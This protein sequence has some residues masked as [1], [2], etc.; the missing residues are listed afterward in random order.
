M[1][2]NGRMLAESVEF[3]NNF[4][5]HGA[6]GAGQSV[7]SCRTFLGRLVENFL[8]DMDKVSA[9]LKKDGTSSE[10][11]APLQFSGIFLRSQSEVFLPPPPSQSPSTPPLNRPVDS[12]QEDDLTQEF[13]MW[14]F[15]RILVLLGHE[16]C[17]A[18][19]ERTIDTIHEMLQAV[20]SRDA[21]LYGRFLKELVLCITDL[22]RIS[23]DMF[24]G[25]IDS[26]KL[27][28]F[29]VNISKVLQSLQEPVKREGSCEVTLSVADFAVVDIYCCESLQL[30]I[31]KILNKI[32][33]DL[34]KFCLESQVNALWA[35][36]CY[37]V[38]EGDLTLKTESL[39]LLGELINYTKVPLEVEEYFIGCLTAM[40]ELLSTG[41]PLVEDATAEEIQ[42]LER[43]AA[44]VFV[45]LVTRG[46]LNILSSYQGTLHT[47]LCKMAAIF[48]SNGLSHLQTGELKRA[49]SSLLCEIQDQLSAQ[50]LLSLVCK[51]QRNQL[52]AAFI[53]EIGFLNDLQYMVGPLVK[54]V[55]C[56]L[57]VK[58]PDNLGN[59]RSL[60]TDDQTPN[61]GGKLSRKRKLDEGPRSAVRIEG[62]SITYKVLKSK[63]NKFLEEDIQEDV[64]KKM[65]GVQIILEIV[66]TCIQMYSENTEAVKQRQ[67]DFTKLTSWLSLESCNEICGLLFRVLQYLTVV[68]KPSAEINSCFI[69]IVKCIG[70]LLIVQEHVEYDPDMYQTL[71]W[72]VSLPWLL[73]DPSWIDLKPTNSRDI[74]KIAGMLV[75]KLGCISNCECLNV[76]AL[77]PKEVAPKWRVHVFRQA[78]CDTVVDVKQTAINVFPIVLF[79]LG[80]NANHLVYDI[81]HPCVEDKSENIHR[82]LAAVCGPLACVVSRKAVINKS[83][84]ISMVDPMYK[85]VAVGCLSCDCSTMIDTAGSS[86]ER[87]RLVDANM[88]LPFLHLVNSDKS[89]IKSALVRSM[90]RMFGHIGVR[91]NNAATISVLNTALNLI[92][93]TDY[94]V[95]TAFSKVIQYLLGDSTVEG[96]EGTNELVLSK[97]R[98]AFSRAQKDSNVRLQETVLLTIAQLGRVSEGEMLMVV[99][100][101]LL[102]S[103]LSITPLVAAVAHEE[104][105]DIADHK[106][107][108]TQ[109]L[110]MRCRHDVCKFLVEAMHNAQIGKLSKSA[111]DI[112]IEVSQ[113]LGFPDVKT[114]LSGT[115]KYIVPYLVSKGTTAASNLIKLIATKLSVVSRSKL[116]INNTKYVFSYLVRFKQKEADLQAAIQYLQKETK[117]ELADLLRIDFQR[118]HNELLLHLGT[119]YSQVFH[120][121]KILSSYDIQYKDGPITTSE[122]MAN[123]LQ[124]RLLGV[125]A[126]FDS[127]LLQSS[128]PME[129]KRPALDSLIS[130][131]RLM[132]SKN[133]SSIRHKVMNTLRI[134]LQFTDKEFTEISCKGWNCFVRSLELPFLGQMLPQI[135]ATLLPLLK[136]LPKQVAEIFNY[137]IVENRNALKSHFHDIYFL[138]DMPELTE[139]NTVLKKYSDGPSSQ[140]DFKS[141]LEH[142]M[143]GIQHD[144]LDVRLHALSKLKKLLKDERQ[145]FFQLV[146]ESETANRTVSSLISVLLKGCREP[147]VRAQRLYAE[148]LGNCSGIDPGRLELSINNPK[149]ELAKLHVS[150]ED[151]KFAVALI[152]EVVKSY[153]AA[154]TPRIQDCSA[155]A[156]QELLSTY[157]ISE[158]SD[159]KHSQ[160]LWNEFKEPIKEILIPLLS[161][162]Y[163]LATDQNWSSLQKPIYCSKKGNSFKDWVSTWTGY[164]S[165]KVKANSKAHK[166][167][168]SCSAML[169]FD[170]HIAIYILPYVVLHVLQ[171][172]SAEDI[173]EIFAEIN[174]VLNQ[175]TRSDGKLKGSN[176]HHMSAQ[177]VF[178]ILDYLTKWKYFMLQL[179][180]AEMQ[181]RKGGSSML[182]LPEEGYNKVKEFLERIPQDK[183]AQ[184]SFSC[185]AYTRALMHFEL[186]L[187]G[188][189]SLSKEQ[190]DFM[191]RLYVEL[192]EPDGVQGM[193]AIRQAPPTLQEQILAFSGRLGCQIELQT[194]YEQA[195]QS[196]P[197]DLNNHQGLLRCLMDLG[198]PSQALHHATGV[199][200]NRK[201]WAPQILP[202]QVEA[203]W[204]LGNWH[205]LE[206]FTKVDKTSRSWPL[207]L[208]RILLAAKAKKED[209]FLQHLQ[210]ARQEQVGPLSAA[211]FEMGS[212]QRG[213][214][215]IVRLHLLNEIEEN[216]HVFMN[217]GED[218]G[219]NITKQDLVSQWQ[220]RL[221]MM[222]SSFRIQEPVLTMRRTL[223]TL[224]EHE[225]QSDLDL[226]REV[227]HSWL[228]SAKIAHKTGNLQT[229]YSFLLQASEFNLP[230][231]CLQKAKWHWEKGEHDQ[232][233]SLLE[234]EMQQ[235]FGNVAQLKADISE[236]G[237]TRRKVYAKA[238]L[239]YGRYCEETSKIESNAIVK[240]YKEVIEVAPD[241]E[242]GY[243]YLGKYFDKIMTAL[244]DDKD[245][246]SKQGEFVVHVVKN[247]ATS[248]RYGNQFIYQSLP[249]LLSLWLDFGTSVVDQEKRERS[250]GSSSS[251]SSQS[252]QKNKNNLSKLNNMIGTFGKTLAPYQLFFAFSQLTSR[253]C[254]AHPEVFLQLKMIIARLV[255]SYPQQALWF[256]MAVSKSSYQMRAKRCQEIFAAAREMQKSLEK[257]IKD[258]LKL[259]DRLLELC[260]KDLPGPATASIDKNFRPLKRLLEDD[261]FTPVLLPLQSSMTVALPNKVDKS[262]N[263][264]PFPGNQVYIR[265]FDDTIEI[266]QSLQK[267]KKITMKGSDGN[268]YVMMCKPKDDLRKDC[269]LMEFNGIVNKF[270]RKDPES[271]KRYLYIRTY[272]VIPLNEECGL[273]EWVNNTSGLRHVLLK[274]YKEKGLYTSGGE[275]KSMMPTVQSPKEVKLNIFKN[276]LLPRH[277]PVFGEWFLRTF[278]DPTS[279]YNARLAYCKTVAVMSMVGYI[280][281]LGDRHGENILFDS[282]SGDCIHVDLNCL[283]NRGE[284]FEWP[285][286]V[287]FRLTH[288][289]VH[290]MGPLKLEGIFRRACEVTL[291]VMRKESEPLMS[292]LKPFVYDPL[293]EWS[294]PSRGHRPNP[295]DSGDITNEQGRVHVH[296]IEQRLQGILNKGTKRSGL[297]LSVE[298]QVNHLI[299]EAT[300]E[301]N[302]CQMYIGWAAYM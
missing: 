267:P 127:Q 74:V 22:V 197:E 188:N 18:L 248:L 113:V 247:L 174:E 302:L 94:D 115:E 35:S 198:Q 151:D 80:P 98:E 218:D 7:Y 299:R 292:M 133:I 238:L 125:L 48:E 175:G 145:A 284:T 87:S 79:H 15:S 62:L 96:S 266:L 214:E 119:N 191:Q 65:E 211:S 169:N 110:F 144:S 34:N 254:H 53:S 163:I 85:N 58:C 14:F 59:K 78:L 276:K 19:H 106:N 1:V 69:S 132:G 262:S 112:L 293:V 186:H 259:T 2:T 140:S 257:V 51:S 264:N 107:T 118:V 300:D 148:C 227:G 236:E 117:F 246:I 206:N 84:E 244:V 130:I 189:T 249:R 194:C 50:Y 240:Q 25:K 278:P 207:M 158:S 88:F 270:L 271:R 187:G 137:M 149:A 116:L 171:D 237:N 95:R 195:I 239:L 164:L 231:F 258:Y 55:M 72:I 168:K 30:N 281:G 91:K 3:L 111:E 63:L 42:N 24:D 221:K 60:V 228:S 217:L 159:D 205:D 45:S 153:L 256:L 4:K 155:Y 185:K 190:L 183:I 294:K 126:Q 67:T 89:D 233:M 8:T 156:L 242:H 251:S 136:Q 297:A 102:E 223:M 33:S 213:Y 166:V 176:Y 280:L 260:E 77:L 27:I 29:P 81:L 32:A 285:E 295:T 192:D 288:N 235:H 83:R 12:M 224:N 143:Q 287:P 232:A 193:A 128:I 147:D 272:T 90:R 167:F 23:E 181:K 101:V 184:V 178:S 229:A 162:K 296:N 73:N 160:K 209:D 129:E 215:Y 75:P 21:F 138:P 216:M 26:D 234:R 97:L 172:G 298:G 200:A 68:E 154:T 226:D 52:V 47:F 201:G 261:S 199:I 204:K 241:W 212:Y 152:N 282:T 245:D 139:A 38:E 121:L 61:T 255:V 219:G 28:R 9:A 76:L 17:A 265:G 105:K 20:C 243:F 157:K 10:Y 291:R 100:I 141:R 131:I 289:L 202:F 134:G 31:T 230:E 170:I 56:D 146:M 123:Y 277:P 161:S 66:S 108:T 208:G 203:A 290:A 273:I 11:L 142:S 182:N 36:L 269:R 225:G 13:L 222:Q 196:E 40:L 275:L 122:E 46:N 103:M 135:I 114:F 173:D 37:H 57:S 253:I 177:T 279:W 64:C 165:S 250:K 44:S 70:A 268:L 286:K 39:K 92:E 99:I 150:I 301:N 43:A 263:H 220:T 71:A 93:D 252:L 82:S 120:G 104:L 109:N 54:A 274:L 49:I 5:K 180:A 16:K 41:L 6:S 124:P 210:I 179:K 86:K 283:F